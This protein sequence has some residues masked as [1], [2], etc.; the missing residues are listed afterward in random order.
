MRRM[1]ELEE[2]RITDLALRVIFSSQQ[3]PTESK[4]KRGTRSSPFWAAR[5][6]PPV[7]LFLPIKEAT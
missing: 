1:S 2:P 4:A 7:V 5:C 6:S 3:N